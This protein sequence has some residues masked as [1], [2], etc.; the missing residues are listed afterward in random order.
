MIIPT[1]TRLSDNLSVTTDTQ[2]RCVIYDITTYTPTVRLV[3]EAQE[4][5]A[6][7]AFWHDGYCAGCGT[8]IPQHHSLCQNCLIEEMHTWGR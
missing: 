3:L 7:I 4:I 5:N 1:L 2:E 6:L 8:G